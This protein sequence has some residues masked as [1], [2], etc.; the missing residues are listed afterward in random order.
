VD[1]ISPSWLAVIL[2]EAALAYQQAETWK[3]SKDPKFAEKKRRIERLTRKRH[4]PPVVV[5]A[6]EMGPISLAPTKGRG[7]HPAGEPH[8]VLT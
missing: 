6:D 5:S 3:V 8:R 7:W 2:D 1:D 4:N